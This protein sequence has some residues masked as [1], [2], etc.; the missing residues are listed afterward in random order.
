ML[1]I[2]SAKNTYHCFILNSESAVTVNLGVFLCSQYYLA[3]TPSIKLLSVY[4]PVTVS[5]TSWNSKKQILP[6]TISSE[7]HIISHLLTLTSLIMLKR[8]P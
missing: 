1:R 5:Q 8:Y 6:S 2:L 3:Y 7:I 4:T